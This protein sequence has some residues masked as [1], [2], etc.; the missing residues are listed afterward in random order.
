MPLGV[1]VRSSLTLENPYV[2]DNRYQNPN[3]E[4][5]EKG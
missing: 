5:N 1:G 3:S 4:M 2:D